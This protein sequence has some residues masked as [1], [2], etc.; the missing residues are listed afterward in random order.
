[1]ERKLDIIHFSEWLKMEGPLLIAG[2]CG[3]ESE[4]QVLQTAKGIAE[5]GKIKI[6]RAGIWKPRTRPNSFE[7]V[8]EIGLKWLS[9]VK[10]Q[11]GFLTAVEVANAAHV[12]K[13]LKH[14]VDILWIGARTT[15]NP[16]SVQEIADAL[17]GVDIPVMVKNPVH[18]D[19]QLWIGAIER[20]NQAGIKKL[21]AIH[22]GFYNPNQTIYRN[23]PFWELAIELRTVFPELPVICD[24][25]HISGKRELIRSV[26][27]KAID[28]GMEGLMIETHNDPATALSDAKQQV[29]PSALIKLLN[30]ELIFRKSF[31]DDKEF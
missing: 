31:S 14:K 2:P 17:K 16:F 8:G 10:T 5:I 1:M 24:P 4:E 11:Y 26:A 12:E 19:L 13:A 22:R 23:D 27:Q 15:V 20:M 29:T 30:E 9:K 6:F 25:S 18:P 28:L 21:I 7:G 3:A